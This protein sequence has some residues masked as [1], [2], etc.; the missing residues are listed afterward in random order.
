M[1]RSKFT[2]L[3][4][5]FLAVGLLAAF[6]TTPAAAQ[7][8]GSIQGTV[9][10]ADGGAPLPGSLVTVEQTGQTVAAGEDGSFVINAVQPGTHRVVASHQ[11]FRPLA[12]EVTVVADQTS[13]VDLRLSVLQFEE[14]V[15]V[16]ATRTARAITD[17]PASVSVVDR[18]FIEDA[19]ARNIQDLLRRTPGIDFVER[20]GMAAR[21]N[22]MIIL[23]GVPGT[24]R[25]LF[26]MDGLPANDLGT[27]T[28]KQLNLVPLQSVEQVEVVR[29]PFSS[30]YGANAF[31]GAINS[32]T[33][34]G[35]GPAAVDLYAG[36]GSS[37][38]S[39]FGAWVRGESGPTA[40]SF[41]VERRAIENV[42]NR[43]ETLSGRALPNVGYDD[44][45]FSG[46]L[47]FAVAES[48]DL[49]VLPR[50]SR[51]TNGL[52]VTTRLPTSVDETRTADSGGLGGVLRQRSDGPFSTEVKFNLRATNDRTSVE[53]HT[54]TGTRQTTVVDQPDGSR[55]EE[56]TRGRQS[57]AAFTE[58]ESRYRNFLIEPQFT[59]TPHGAHTVVFGVNYTNDR[60]TFGDS[61]IAD[62]ANV[63]GSDQALM[64]M[65]AGI[66][67]DLAAGGA[68][69]P[70]VSLVRD[71]PIGDVFPLSQGS[72]EIFHEASGYVQDEWDV[73]D[74]LRLVPGAR[75]DYHS[76]FGSV[77]SPRLA[78]LYTMTPAARV[79]ASAGRAFRAPSLSELF[80]NVVFHGTTPGFPNPDLDPEYITSFDGGLQYEVGRGLRTEINV[81]HNDMT[82]LIQLV[83]AP[84]RTRLDWVNV[85]DARSTGIELVAQGDPAGWFSYYTNYT[86]T[87]SE[88]RESGDPLARVP[89]HKVNVGLQ[90]DGSLGSW[91]VTGSLDHR[92]VSERF[93]TS[94]GRPV[95]LEPYN[96]TDLGFSVRPSDR[97]RVGVHVLNLFDAYYEESFGSPVAARMLSVQ[98]AV[99]PF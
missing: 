75:F 78:M 86:L 10:I 47:D 99:T 14:E 82:N 97:M 70:S 94:R 71:P 69:N 95:E 83:L 15:F 65:A 23:R 48:W 52:G 55:L 31:S 40:Y 93:Q 44:L 79:R 68:L 2:S 42:Y 87:D 7:E 96:R 60:G 80:G 88:D 62:H 39:Q 16:T 85:A 38:Y 53:N 73:T 89:R 64:G 63:L 43:E 66:Q 4:T 46:R 37:T 90:L 19:P 32:I 5:S 84:S 22:S 9:T 91:A 35:E 12:L 54:R 36:G 92:W 98:V 1:Y 58:R 29:G 45:R 26:M 50:A 25:A 59:W 20:S 34:R 8:T 28:L 13:R 24:K 6:G 30:L 76:R 27:G 56:V 51:F 17:V 49:T 33:R 41:T 11:A 67:A 81:F 61:L 72:R 77:S 74:D 3:L 21:S 18:E 57:F